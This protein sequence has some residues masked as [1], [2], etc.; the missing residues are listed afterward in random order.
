M[1]LDIEMDDAAETYEERLP[2]FDDVQVSRQRV[3]FGS[4]SARRQRA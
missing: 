2:D 1:D 3:I 4:C